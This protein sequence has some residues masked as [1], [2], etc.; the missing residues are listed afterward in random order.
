MTEQGRK[1]NIKVRSVGLL[2]PPL[3]N[4]KPIPSKNHKGLGVNLSC[5]FGRSA[6]SFPAPINAPPF[7]KI[8]G[9]HTN[10]NNIS[11]HATST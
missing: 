11:Q 7:L 1:L 10:A 3:E 8:R 4:L 6:S 9:V 5:A 2:G